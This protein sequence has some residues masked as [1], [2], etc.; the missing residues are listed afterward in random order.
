MVHVY[1]ETVVAGMADT[2]VGGVFAL[3]EEPSGSV[4]QPMPAGNAK[5]AVALVA[6]NCA[7]PFNAAVGFPRGSREEFGSRDIEVPPIVTTPLHGGMLYA[8]R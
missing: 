2:S 3:E 1:A 4:G 8:R 5:Y 6:P 7:C